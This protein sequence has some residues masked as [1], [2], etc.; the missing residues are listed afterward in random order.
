VTEVQLTR[1]Q[2]LLVRMTAWCLKRRP[3]RAA[4]LKRALRNSFAHRGEDVV[5]A[6]W[7]QARSR[8]WDWDR[9]AV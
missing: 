3:D 4:E 5:D 7:Q 1:W 2:R 6:M 9:S 8:A